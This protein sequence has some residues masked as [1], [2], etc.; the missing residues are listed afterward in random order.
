MKK[1]R[2]LLMVITFISI[3]SLFSSC[4]SNDSPSNDASIVGEWKFDN[5]NYTGNSTSDDIPGYEIRIEQE[6]TGDNLIY[7]FSEN[8]NTMERSGKLNTIVRT[9]VNNQ[10]TGTDN[11]VYDYD[12]N[13]V[14]PTSWELNGD[15]IIFDDIPFLDNGDVTLEV[16]SNTLIS[17]VTTL[18]DTNMVI[19]TSGILTTK[20]ND[21]NITFSNEIN[22]VANFTRN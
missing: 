21:T 22:A 3:T 9:Y 2:Q 18:T 6:L 20:D 11:I 15:E 7:T 8:P 1:S 17:R 16:V 19:E 10:L 14:D 13:P 5:G 12:E 4:G